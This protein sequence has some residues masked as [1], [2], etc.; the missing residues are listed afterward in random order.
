MQKII[1]LDQGIE[2]TNRNLNLPAI[3]FY[4]E[5][6]ARPDLAMRSLKQVPIIS[7]VRLAIAQYYVVPFDCN[8]I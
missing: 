6:H 5:Y 7:L 8:C 2:C 1:S 4:N 3:G